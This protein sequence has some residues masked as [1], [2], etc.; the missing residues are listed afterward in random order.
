MV[1]EKNGLKH[2]AKQCL[3]DIFAEKKL[4]AEAS[5]CDLWIDYTTTN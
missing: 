1:T 4:N 2:L 5:T 3:A